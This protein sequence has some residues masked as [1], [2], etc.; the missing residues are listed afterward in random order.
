MTA[1]ARI[2]SRGA[3]VVLVTVR[4]MRLMLGLLLVLFVTSETWRYM[5]RLPV[6]RLVL[7]VLITLTAAL[8]V[9]GLGL[10]HTLASAAVRRATTRVA[11]EV[12]AFGAALF[13]V[14][15]VVG[16]LSVDA[17]LVAEWTGEPGGV[18][19]WLGIGRPSMV[20]TAPLLQVAAFLASL[21]L[22]P[23]PWRW[24]PTPAHVNYSSA[25]WSNRD[26]RRP[27]RGPDRSTPGRQ[28]VSE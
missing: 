9:V 2:A 22:S 23:S 8:L 18:L 12:V 19:L 24:S 13:L 17:D 4:E 7:L 10:R 28:V 16:V 6:P 25:T 3:D 15:A 1:R 20:L 5:G 11:V 26:S 14:F 27:S 21:G